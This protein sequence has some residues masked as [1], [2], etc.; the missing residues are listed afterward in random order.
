LDNNKLYCIS[1]DLTS[2]VYIFDSYVEGARTL[3]P[4]KCANFSDIELKVYKNIR[5]IHRN[6]NTTSLTKTELGSF[7]LVEHPETLLRKKRTNKKIVYVLN[8]ITGQI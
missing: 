2:I 7:Y 4:L 3:T 6:I 8:L 1:S 5:H